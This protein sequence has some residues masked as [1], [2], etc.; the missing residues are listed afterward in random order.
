MQAILFIGIQGAGKSTFYWQ[1][2]FNS[3]VRISLDLL[4]TRNRE[5]KFL[6]LCLDSQSRFVVDN[7]NP[8][9]D[10][11]MRY[12][13]PAK[14]KKYEIIGYFF[15]A[16]FEEANERNQQRL[17]KARIPEAGLRHYLKQFQK[18]RIEE[19]FDQLYR[20]RLV[21]GIFIQEIMNNEI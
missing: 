19:G 10:E 14:E 18:P 1:N 11:R 20:V 15:D 5:S 9:A 7:T 12:I 13:G 2:F 4:K 6:K 17:G 16:G 21:N 3:H 8:T